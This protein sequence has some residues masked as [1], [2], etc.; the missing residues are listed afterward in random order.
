MEHGAKGATFDKK[1]LLQHPLMKGKIGPDHQ[2]PVFDPDYTPCAGG[3]MKTF[4]TTQEEVYYR[5][6]SGRT[7]GSFLTKI[8]PESAAFAREAFALPPGNT[9]QFVQEVIVPKGVPLQRSRALPAFEKRGA[10]EQF[11]VLLKKEDLTKVL[12]FKTGLPLL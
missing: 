8:K 1:A 12:T 6:Y 10:A 7:S 4:F 11:E 3:Y 5:V 2:I 9:A